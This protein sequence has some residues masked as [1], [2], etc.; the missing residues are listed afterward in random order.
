MAECR[1]I[2]MFLSFIILVSFSPIFFQTM[3]TT[4]AGLLWFQMMYY[5]TCTNLK[6]MFS[7]L[8]AT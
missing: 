3:E 6:M 2:D 8:L 7:L 1:D 4:R 5:D